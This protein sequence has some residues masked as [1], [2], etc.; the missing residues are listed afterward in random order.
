MVSYLADTNV[1]EVYTGAAWVSLDD[2]NAIQNTLLTT[3]GDTI[4]ASSANTPARLAVGTSGQVLTVAGGVPTWA[5]AAGAL[6][7][8]SSNTFSGVSSV[9]LPTNSFSATYRNYLVLIDFNASS[10]SNVMTIRR[11]ISGTDNSASE[12]YAGGSATPYTGAT[13][14]I[15]SNASSSWAT[16][17]NTSNS[18]SALVLNV[19]EPFTGAGS[20]IVVN[21][22]TSE[23]AGTTIGYWASSATAYD[24]LSFILAAGTFGGAYEIYGY[25][26]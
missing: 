8:I 11:R 5:A 20:R 3:T 16:N 10:G 13:V 22:I 12:Y 23:M 26:N 25:Q 17:M 21:G 19:F 2:P 7:K 6:T 1:V 14:A 15:Q 4:Y 9:S 18:R 24:S